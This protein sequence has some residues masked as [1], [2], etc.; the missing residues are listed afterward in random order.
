MLRSRCSPGRSRTR[1]SA[2]VVRRSFRAGNRRIGVA[3]RTGDGVD[4]HASGRAAA[5]RSR[6]CLRRFRIA[7]TRYDCAVRGHVCAC[8]V[9]IRSLA[10]LAPRP[11][12]RGDR[13]DHQQIARRAAIG[14]GAA[15]LCYRS[16]APPQHR[17]DAARKTRPPSLCR[18][19]THTRTNG[20]RG[21]RCYICSLRHAV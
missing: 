3:G 10:A 15:H 6:R 16:R 18:F 9:Y 19:L 4:R 21:F 7:R 12:H 1:T 2:L 8:N 20:T 17:V 13:R 11:D 5:R 14:C